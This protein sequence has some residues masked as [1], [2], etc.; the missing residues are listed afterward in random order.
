MG[1]QKK[2]QQ[3]EHELQCNGLQYTNFNKCIQYKYGVVKPDQFGVYLVKSQ[4]LWKI[5]ANIID[6]NQT[7]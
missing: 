2:E 4:N 1:E 7:K 3:R 6:L 5:L